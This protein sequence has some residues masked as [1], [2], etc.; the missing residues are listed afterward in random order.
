[1]EFAIAA[2]AFLRFLG[3]QTLSDIM[4]GQED[5][6]RATAGV[7]Q[8]PGAEQHGAR[9][10]TFKRVGDLEAAE[11][12]V[13][14]NDLFKQFAQFRDVPLAIDQLINQTALRFGR[15]NIEGLIKCFIGG[16]DGQVGLENQQRI[17]QRTM[18]SVLA[19]FSDLA[20]V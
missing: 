4:D 12:G 13:P 11:E 2:N 18:A 7:V 9:A 17:A 19:R 14:W 15:R 3:E 20:F 16:V 10:E 8:H 6:P 1:M 5:A